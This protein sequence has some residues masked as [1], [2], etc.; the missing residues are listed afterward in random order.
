[1]ER[2]VPVEL[3]NM[4]M[5]YDGNKVLVEEKILED[6]KGII[7][8]GGHIER[9]ESITASVIR[10]IKEETGLT[11]RNPQLCGVKDWI[12]E[13]GTRYLVFLY[14]TNQFSGEL[15]SSDEG[16]VFWIERSELEAMN[17]IWNLKELMYI[18][19]TEEFGEF[20]FMIENDKWEGKLL[21]GI[22]A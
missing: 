7:F 6:G 9:G 19:E 5:V 1:M 20:F 16:R 15:I 8:P 4:C 21:G 17:P 14:K 10:E 13:D 18:F 22:E 11:I 2:R 3:T 12:E